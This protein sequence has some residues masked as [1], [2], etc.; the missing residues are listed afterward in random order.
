MQGM[1]VR[2]HACMVVRAPVCVRIKRTRLRIQMCM[3]LLMR[4]RA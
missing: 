2:T 3:L 1:L 4:M